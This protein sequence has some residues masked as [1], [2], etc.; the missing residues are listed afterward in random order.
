MHESE[1]EVSPE[2]LKNKKSSRQHDIYNEFLKYLT[3]ELTKIIEKIMESHMN[4]A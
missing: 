1:E 3:R 2:K 4:S